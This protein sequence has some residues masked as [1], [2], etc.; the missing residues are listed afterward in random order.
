MH[1]AASKHGMPPDTFSVAL[2]QSLADT[3]YQAISSPSSYRTRDIGEAD[4][5]PS[6][7]VQSVRTMPVP[8]EARR[9]QTWK[10]SS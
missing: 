10:H 4:A 6:D 3:A 2:L 7:R 9:K 1:H 8:R 5:L